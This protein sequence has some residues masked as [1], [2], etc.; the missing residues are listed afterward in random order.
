MMKQ[1][2]GWQ[3]WTAV[4]LLCVVIVIPAILACYWVTWKIYLFVIQALWPTGPYT[5]THVE[6][7]VFVGVSFLLQLLFARSRK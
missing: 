5:I 2:K 3:H 4:F 1:G 6:F 7:W